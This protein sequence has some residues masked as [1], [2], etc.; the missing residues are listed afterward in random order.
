MMRAAVILFALLAP[1][2]AAA[3]DDSQR[4]MARQDVAALVDTQVNRPK[5]RRAVRLTEEVQLKR[6]RPLGRPEERSDLALGAQTLPQLRAEENLFAFSPTAPV[7]SLAPQARSAAFVQ[8]IANRQAALVRGQV[9]SDPAI[10]GE[11]IGAVSGQGAC[12]IDDAVRIRSVAG[13]QVQPATRMDCQTAS[14]LKDWVVN[15]V[16]QATQ[17]QAASLRVVSGYSCRFRNAAASGKLSEHAYGRAIDIA[18]VGLKSGREVTVLTGWNTA[19]D[20][21]ALRAMWQ[22]ACRHFGTV[23]GP[24]ANRFHRDHFHFDTARY[25]SGSYCR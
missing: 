17:G 21:A 22:S 14:A 4:P 15:G 8:D 6:V 25:R 24:D 2:T 18:G 9:C 23:L 20:G 19:R 7:N 16:Q 1:V 11:A 10:Q 13:V 5:A 12:G 3:Q